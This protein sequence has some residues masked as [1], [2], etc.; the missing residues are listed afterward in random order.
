MSKLNVAVIFGGCS[1]EHDISI[2]SAST[3]ISNIPTSK[4]N[5]IPIYITKEGKWLLY[6]GEVTNIK[7]IDF[8]K[9]GT[10]T[11]ISTDRDRKGVMRMVGEKFKNVKIDVFFPVLHGRNGED[12]TIQG[13]FEIADVPYVGCGV[14]SSAVSMDKVFTKLIVNNTKI[15]QASFLSFKKEDLED[16]NAVVKRIRSKLGYP[17]FV[18][19]AIS[20]SSIGISKANDK[21]ELVEAINIAIKHDSKIL[22]EKFIKGRELECAVLGSGGKDTLVSTVG[23][24][25]AADEFYDF[26]SKYNNPESKTIIPAE[27]PEEYIKEIQNSALEIFKLLNCSGLSRVDFF[28]EEGTNKIFFNEINTLPGFTNISMYPMLCDTMGFSISDLL[29]KLIQ[30]ALVRD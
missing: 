13:I 12:G 11:T 3:I 9:F 29:D 5:V 15:K 20:G 26:E 14:L 2:E 30:L 16:M 27:I 1:Y 23:E 6:D 24:V 21:K 25:D 7:N 4:Y 19:P 22:V 17:C 8:E 28:L 10:P 18:K